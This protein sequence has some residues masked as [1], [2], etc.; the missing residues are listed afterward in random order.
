MSQQSDKSGIP[1]FLGR[2]FRHRIA[3]ICVML[4]LFWHKAEP[5]ALDMTKIQ[6]TEGI[7]ACSQF[8][9]HGFGARKPNI[10]DSVVYYSRFSYIFG[11]RPS[12]SCFSELHGHK[13]RMYYLLAND[14]NQRIGLELVD[15]QS[16][17]IFGI[18]KEQHLALYQQDV[19]DTFWFYS[20]KLGLL[21]LVLH[22]T[23]WSRVTALVQSLALKLH[24]K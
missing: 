1:T 3:G 17:R 13:V 12:T 11:L 2:A 15:L 23:L 6:V 8:Y 5:P 9:R 14:K 22:L 19:A 10:V 21:L 18:T 20:S 7:Y 4:I 24:L 16:N